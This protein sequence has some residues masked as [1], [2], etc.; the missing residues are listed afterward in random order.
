[1]AY[2]IAADLLVLL[3][4]AFILMVLLGGFV[5]LRHRWFALAHL[6]AV[7]WGAAVELCGWTCP[8]TPWEQ[9][10]RR[11]AGDAGYSGGF[12]EHYLLELIYPGWLTSDIQVA[13]GV[14]VIVL[15]LATYARVLFR[16]SRTL[17]H[18]P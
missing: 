3:H 14:L 17:G 11:L 9:N 18:P 16:R 2:R 7:A 12:I 8:L 10:L 4:F 13:M 6:P 5:V 15:N 1:M